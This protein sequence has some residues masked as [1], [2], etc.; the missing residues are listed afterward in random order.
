M[1]RPIEMLAVRPVTL[2]MAQPH[3]VLASGAV[4]TS[5]CHWNHYANSMQPTIQC[6]RTRVGHWIGWF[7]K[8]LIPPRMLLFS[9]VVLMKPL[10]PC[11]M[12]WNW[13]FQ[14]LLRSIDFHDLINTLWLL[15]VNVVTNLPIQINSILLCAI[16]RK[17]YQSKIIKLIS[18]H[19]IIVEI[20][21]LLEKNRSFNQIT[22]IFVL[23]S[24]AKF[25]F[26]RL[27]HHKTFD[28]QIKANGLQIKTKKTHKNVV[29]KCGIKTNKFGW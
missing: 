3:T 1:R 25:I 19:R 20:S 24:R 6:E 7:S 9:L 13:S 27:M 29:K 26:S 28:Q 22:Y 16:H 23:N 4:S 17:K 18:S 15:L 11:Q 12:N 14:M 5:N 21:L 10:S 8:W 2:A